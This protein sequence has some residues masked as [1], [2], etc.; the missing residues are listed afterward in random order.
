MGTV[1][2]LFFGRALVASERQYFVSSSCGV[3]QKANVKF[4]S[5][6]VVPGFEKQNLH[7]LALSHPAFY[8]SN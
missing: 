5:S 8:K 7:S 4:H 2:R 3:K 1:W 6:E